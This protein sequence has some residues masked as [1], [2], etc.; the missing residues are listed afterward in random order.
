MVVVDGAK[1][2]SFIHTAVCTFCGLGDDWINY[3]LTNSRS[4]GIVS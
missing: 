4:K 1:E 2:L 3:F